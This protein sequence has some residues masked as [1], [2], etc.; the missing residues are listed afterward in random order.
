MLMC[1]I[2]VTLVIIGGNSVT[3]FPSILHTNSFNISLYTGI[4]REVWPTSDPA[5]RVS[6]PQ[7]KLK[8]VYSTFLKRNLRLLCVAA[9]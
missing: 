5:I 3:A 6:S 7:Q 4:I 1:L 8:P 2:Q 9:L